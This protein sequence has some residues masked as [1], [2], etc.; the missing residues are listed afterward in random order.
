MVP[1]ELLF[2]TSIRCWSPPHAIA[3]TV[4][5]AVSFNDLHYAN[6]KMASS[7]TY[8]YEPIISWIEP[9]FGPSQATRHSSIIVHGSNFLDQPG[10][11]CRIA[12]S[13]SSSVMTTKATYVYADEILCEMPPES[14]LTGSQPLITVSLNGVD[15]ASGSKVAYTYVPPARLQ[16]CTAAMHTS[17]P[18]T[19]NSPIYLPI[20]PTYRDSY[21]R[22]GPSMEVPSSLSWVKV[23]LIA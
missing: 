8:V 1:A 21:P 14:A 6:K 16:V 3:E 9:S 23:S 19:A 4:S 2:D 11:A 22:Q 10:L 15:F 5:V 13:S 18:S 12:S 17:M 20:Y 7:F